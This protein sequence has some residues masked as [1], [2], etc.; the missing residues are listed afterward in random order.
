M[1]LAELSLKRPVTA[2][3]FFVVL[4]VIGL[5]AG[6]RLQMEYFPAIDVPFLMVDIPYVGSTPAEIERTITH[7]VEDA[8]AALPGIQKMQSTSRADD[9]QIMLQFKWGENVAVKAV[10][11]R[12]K[13]DAI[14]ADLP[15]DLQRYTVQKFSTSDQPI[16]QLRIASSRNLSNSYALLDRVLK[17]PLERIPGVARVDI[18]GVQ[19]P[20]LQIQVSAER[21]AA[22]GVSLNQL[23]Q[24]LKQANFSLSAGEVSDG[25][26]RWRVQPQGQWRDLDDVRALPVNAQGLKL[27]D[28]AQVTLQPAKMDFARDLNGRPAIGVDIYKERNANLVQVGSA[29]TKYVDGVRGD[30]QMHG[31][32]VYAL[33][34][35]AKG[36]TSSLRELAEAGAIGVLLSVLVLYFFLRDWP[37][38]LMVSLA[39]PVCFVITLGCMYFFGISLNILSMMGLLL[40]VGMLVDN[41]VVVVESIYQYREKYPDKPWYCAVAGTQA[42]GIAI[43]AGTLTSVIV[44]LPNVF[45]EK[46]DISIF[47]TQVAITMAIAHIASWLVAVSLVPMLSSRLPPPKF[48][49]R[50]TLVTR[51]RDRYARV[52]AWTLAHRRWS[53]AGVFALLVL[54]FWPMTHMKVDMFAQS[55]SRQLFLNWHLNGQY[56]LPQLAVAVNKIDGWLLAHKKELEIKSVYTY[57]SETQGNSTT[58]MLSEGRDAHRSSAEIMEAIRKGLPKI[59]I[60][61]VDFNQQNNG[62]APVEVSLRGDSTAQL[63]QLSDTLVPV[64]ARLPS[65]RDVHAAERGGD[66]E[67]AVHVDRVR[68]KQYGFDAQSVGN[69]VAVAL[70]GMPLSEYRQGDREVPVWLR[71]ANSDTASLDDLSDYQLRRD[72]GTQ[73][74]LLSMVQVT[75]HPVATAIDRTDRQTTVTIRANLADGKTTEDARKEINNV[76]KAV[77]LPPG[78]HWA[79]GDNFDNAQQAGN[80]MAFNMLIALV[81]VYVV[82]CCMFESLIFPAAILTTFIFSVLG[83]FW[84]FWATGTTFSIMAAIGILILMGVV[85]SNGIV[86]IVHINMLRHHGMGRTQALIAGASERLRPILMTMG[87]A[88]LGMLPLCLTDAQLGGNGP[89]YSPMARAIAGGLLFSTIVTLLALP[90]IYALLDDSRMAVRRVMRDA[91]AGR[92]RRPRGNVGQLPALG[93]ALVSE[94][95]E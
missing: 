64:L 69:Y 91:R 60:G 74:P 14:R 26:K 10:Q 84:L 50:K 16:L 1:N 92:V 8:L 49:N 30:P 33:Q 44:F 22:H 75:T 89:P 51:L 43:A 36:V 73:I 59:A 2:V 68:A 52:V 18:N 45:G 72:D 66:R 88:I 17:R 70:R 24:R 55:E 76:M 23:Y 79:F 28:I 5:I 83:V 11:A 37:S 15:S 31:I 90:V 40:A 57:Y 25:G 65:L 29:V 81:L 35:S 39:I 80:Q 82:M 19:A 53:M 95:T 94:I 86:M 54:S 46:N 47:L 13:I 78:Y 71:F 67:V 27:G 93:A 6:F 58:I 87:T 32:N 61:S 21:L 77:T 63:E 41:A 9:A 85:V 62:S 7:P 34:D 3:M 42:V 48:L 56:R 20:E 4:V 12:E 38:T